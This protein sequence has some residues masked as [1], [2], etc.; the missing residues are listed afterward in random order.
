MGDY[1]PCC[2]SGLML[3][4]IFQMVIICMIKHDNYLLCCHSCSSANCCVC[5][6][7]FCK[8]P[9]CNA[10]TAGP[11]CS[12]IALATDHFDFCSDSSAYPDFVTSTRSLNITC[13]HGIARQCLRRFRF[14]TGI[15][16]P[17][18]ILN[19]FTDRHETL[20]G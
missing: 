4:P 9:V 13:L 11:L 6:K 7:K 12:I 3:Q 17:R 15:C 8:I 16:R 19:P 14:P 2:F 18:T 10:K 1:W 5:N 20:H